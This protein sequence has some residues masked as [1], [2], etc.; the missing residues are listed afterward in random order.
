MAV[1]SGPRTIDC[2]HCGFRYHMGLQVE[3]DDVR[4]RRIFSPVINGPGLICVY[5]MMEIESKFGLGDVP[6]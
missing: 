2:A 4:M 1:D 6:F 3:K 5:C